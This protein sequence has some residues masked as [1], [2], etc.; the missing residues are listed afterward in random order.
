MSYLVTNS[1]STMYYHTNTH[2]TVKPHSPLVAHFHDFFNVAG[3]AHHLRILISSSSSRRPTRHNRKHMFN[4]KILSSYP[5][6]CLIA[7]II[8]HRTCCIVEPTAQP[9]EIV[10]ALRESSPLMVSIWIVGI[11]Y[12]SQNLITKPLPKATF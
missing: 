12:P 2:V 1:C 3:Q 7:Q 5:S 4:N 6:W 8:Q 10:R 9:A 11:D